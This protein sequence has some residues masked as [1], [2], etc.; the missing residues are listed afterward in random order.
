MNHELTFSCVDLQMRR[1]VEILGNPPEHVLCNGV[2][3]KHYFTKE[4]TNTWRL[5]TPEEYRRVTLEDPGTY[6]PQVD[7][8]MLLE[9]FI[10]V[11]PQSRTCLLFRTRGNDSEVV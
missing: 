8:P 3:T 1:M 5:L 9:D 6:T 7:E 10:R 2:Y 4:D 11:S